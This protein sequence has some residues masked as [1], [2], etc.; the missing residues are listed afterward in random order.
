MNRTVRVNFRN[1][2]PKQK[3]YIRCCSCNGSG[4]SHP[5]KDCLTCGGYGEIEE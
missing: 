2:K 5:D 4:M 3:N 1:T